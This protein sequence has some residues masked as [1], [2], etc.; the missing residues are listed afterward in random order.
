[1]GDFNKDGLPDLYFTAS[2]TGNKLYINKGNLKF[3]DVTATA[4]VS[5]EGMWSNAA[6]VI[7]INGDGYEDIYVCTTIKSDPK[8]RRNLLYINQGKQSDNIPRFKEMAAEYGLADTSYSVH[9]AFLDYDNDGDLDMYLVTTKLAKRSSASFAIKDTSTADMDKLFRNDWN[10]QLGHPVFTDVSKQAGIADHG[11]G[12]GIAVTDINRDGWKDIYVTNDFFGSDHLYIN[13]KNGTF[14]EHVRDYFKHTSRNAMGNDVADINNDGLAD[15]FTVDMNPESNYRKKKNMGGNN[16]YEYQSMLFE[17]VMLQYVRNTMQLNMGPRINSN[18]SVGAPVFS[19]IS[20]YTGTAETDWSWNPS[21]DD[22]DNDGNRDLI[23]TNGYPRDVTDHDF[24]AFRNNSMSI[25]SKEQLINEMPAI[26]IPNAAYKNFGNLKFENTTTQWGLDQ[27]SFSNGA[28][29]VDLDNDGD[30]DYVINNID[31][32]AFVYENTTNSK[33]DIRK[34]FLS[35]TFNGG[36][37]NP[38]GIGVWG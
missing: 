13:N 34:N 22:F 2:T 1:M 21:V 25:A 18:D 23:I 4:A 12:L 29:A 26:K 24:I 38:N 19:D 37:Q 17:N 8:Q 7:D 14:S 5:G 30:L 15:I 16:Y 35:I 10:A 36:K 6:S 32:E 20:F 33:N 28:V 11:F 3:E 27:P 31:D 9:A